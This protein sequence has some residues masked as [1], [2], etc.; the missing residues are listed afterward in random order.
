MAD[1]GQGTI[2]VPCVLV[3]G[4]PYSLVVDGSKYPYVNVAVSALPSGAATAANQASLLTELAKKLDTADL[5]ITA[6]KELV[7]LLRALVGAVETSLVAFPGG[8]LKVAGGYGSIAR[9]N[10]AGVLSDSTDWTTVTSVSGAGILETIDFSTNYNYT[11]LNVTID[12]DQHVL[13]ARDGSTVYDPCPER[14][15]LIGDET[16]LLK[17]TLFD[18]TDN[19]YVIILKRAVQFNSS[20]AIKVRQYSG[21]DQNVAVEVLRRSIG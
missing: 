16:S 19:Y 11:E 2:V 13:I 7:V 10:R 5:S 1:E 20:L 9:D 6:S 4:V 3:N 15:H 21:S 12:G 14:L 17:Q 18:D 8:I